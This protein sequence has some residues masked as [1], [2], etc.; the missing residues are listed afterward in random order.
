MGPFFRH[1]GEA[2][3]FAMRRVCHS[4]APEFVC[5]GDLLFSDGEVSPCPVMYFCNEG[6]LIYGGPKGA[7][8]MNKGQWACEHVLWTLWVHCGQLHAKTE[9]HLTVL[10]AERF[11]KIAVHF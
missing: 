6:H 9:C 1:Y 2:N 4:V 11:Q 10:S 5:R 7:E 8:E 3:C